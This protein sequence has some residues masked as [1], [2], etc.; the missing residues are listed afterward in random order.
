[1]QDEKDRQDQRCDCEDES[2]QC[3]LE[4]LQAQCEQYLERFMRAQAELQNFRKRTER[5]RQQ[6]RQD[7]QAQTVEQFL[8]VIDNLE[9]VLQAA[10]DPDPVRDGVA[11]I[12]G[13]VQG[14][15][16]KVGVSR[17]CTVG[18]PFDPHWHEALGAIPTTDYPEGTVVEELLPGYRMEDR[19]VRPAQVMVAKRLC[20]QQHD[21]L[22][23]NKNKEED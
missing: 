15:L 21:H 2:E 3:S 20:H 13:Q 8:P 4:D 12:L 5:Q 14:I 18:E 11:M 7:V 22:V 6:L 16:E 17:M 9:R 19:L 1:M 23:V 10:D